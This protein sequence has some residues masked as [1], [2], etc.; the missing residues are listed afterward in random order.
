MRARLLFYF[1]AAMP[2]VVSAESME[3]W[4]RSFYNDRGVCAANTNVGEIKIADNQLIAYLDVENNYLKRVQGGGKEIVDDWL[5]L[6]CPFPLAAYEHIF[7]GY[8][9]VI[10]AGNNLS[11]SCRAYK[12]SW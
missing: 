5:A 1:V 3:D 10:T 8:D 4:L 7:N 9:I 2:A 12:N 6:H 11:L